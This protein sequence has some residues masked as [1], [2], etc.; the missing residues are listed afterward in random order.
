MNDIRTAHLQLCRPQ[1]AD[2]E[3]FA[4]MHENPKVMAT[5]GGVRS[6]EQLR[7]WFDRLLLHWERHEYGWWVARDLESGAFAGRGGLAHVAV[8]G[9]DEVEV[10]YRFLPAFWGRGLATELARESIHQGFDTLGLPEL[11]S[12]TLVTNLASRRVME[13]TGFRYE[14]DFVHTNFPHVLYR[15]HNPRPKL[16]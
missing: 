2:W 8:E 11:V 4:L 6:R 15:Q 1:S 12:F 3:D 10:G 13:K 16:S 9:R 14:R 5:L 7:P